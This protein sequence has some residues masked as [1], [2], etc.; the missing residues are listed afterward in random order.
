MMLEP[1]MS[2]AKHGFAYGWTVQ[3]A[4]SPAYLEAATVPP[5]L[6]SSAWGENYIFI[7]FIPFF[8]S[9]ALQD[10]H[11]EAGCLAGRPCSVFYLLGQS[12]PPSPPYSTYTGCCAC[13]RAYLDI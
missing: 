10:T 5:N 8:V 11:V 2:R 7:I 1:G 6:S 13:M 4:P 3:D 12:W 9:T